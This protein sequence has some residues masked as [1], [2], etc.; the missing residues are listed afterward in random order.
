[1]FWQLGLF[2]N[3]Y[4]YTNQMYNSALMQSYTA[5]GSVFSVMPSAY[6]LSAYAAPAVT[7]SGFLQTISSLLASIKTGAKSVVSSVGSGIR[8]AVSYVSSS[9][10]NFGSR[11][12]SKAKSFLGYK[13]SDGSY[14]LFTSGRTEA[15]CADFV[16]YCA[17]QCGVKNFNYRGVQQILDWG[18]KNN[19]FSTTPKVGDAIIFKGR[20]SNGSRASHTG[21]VTRVANGRVYTIEGNTSDK[22]AERSYSLNDSRITGYVTIA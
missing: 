2:N 22:V 16:S 1:M 7:S 4:N 9:I 6:N 20:K 8:S 14:K 15:W 11:L 17:R 12:V 3:P 19:R 10:S 21:V 5:P 13:E 18:R